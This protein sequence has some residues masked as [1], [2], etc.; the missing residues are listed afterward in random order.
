MAGNP[1]HYVHP[2][3]PPGREPAGPPT[4]DDLTPPCPSL[5]APAGEARVLLPGGVP[6]ELVAVPA[7]T[8]QLGTAETAPERWSD[9]RQHTATVGAF[10]LG[11][12]PV[13]QAQWHA[14]MATSPAHF[15]DCGPECPVENVSWH[16]CQAFAARLNTLIGC[17]FRLPTEAEWEYACRAGGD[18]TPPGAPRDARAWT[19]D[20]AGQ[21]PHPVGRKFCNPWGLYDM[22]GL[23]WQWCAD[24]Y[25]PEPG[26]DTRRGTTRALRGGSFGDNSRSA[27]CAAR[28]SDGA[29]VRLP[30]YGCRIAR[31]R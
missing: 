27:R 29:D 4:A 28:D 26:A 12:T 8:A 18:D 30:I 21:R 11:K 13:T 22:P 15:A 17:G 20:N 23:I 6:L 14:V 5:P 9:E 24:R 3:V 1:P 7:G 19:W 2:V 16:D 10:W 31:S 25:V